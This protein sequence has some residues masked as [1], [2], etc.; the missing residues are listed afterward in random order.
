MPR[1]FVMF[2]PFTLNPQVFCFGYVG[3]GCFLFLHLTAYR[4]VQHI[5]TGWAVQHSV[6]IFT[7]FR[8][9]SST[10]G[11]SSASPGRFS[12]ETTFWHPA[13]NSENWLRNDQTVRSCC[14]RCFAFASH[15]YVW[16][17]DATNGAPGLTT[18]SKDATRGSY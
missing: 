11:S 8:T 3:L 2:L 13:R 10:V 4:C 14:E 16:S 1:S 12:P 7:A 17:R 18:R 5:Q 15:R 6:S 9:R